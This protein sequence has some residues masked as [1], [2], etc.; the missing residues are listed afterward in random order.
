MTPSAEALREALPCY[1]EPYTNGEHSVRCPAHYNP[2]IA[3]AVRAE[4]EKVAFDVRAELWAVA[5]RH[6]D[7]GNQAYA[8]VLTFAAGHAFNTIMKPVIEGGDDA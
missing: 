5:E 1:C 4:R 7:R 3:A 6:A 2:A 8:D